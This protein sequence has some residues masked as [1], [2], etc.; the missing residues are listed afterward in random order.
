MELFIELENG[1][2]RG[3]LSF[4]FNKET[5]LQDL[6][7]EIHVK[8]GIQPDDQILFLNGKLLEAV[9][10]SDHLID[11]NFKNKDIIVVRY[12]EYAR[13]EV[14][15]KT[16]NELFH[17]THSDDP[18]VKYDRFQWCSEECRR[19]YG[20]KFDYTF[21]ALLDELYEIK[22]KILCCTD[23]MYPAIK[24]SFI[25]YFRKVFPE[26]DVIVGRKEKGTR[27]GC[28]VR[29]SLNSAVTKFYVK[30]QDNIG[31]MDFLCPKNHPSVDIVELY[32]YKLLE[33]IG[34]C[35]DGHFIHN[36]MESS[37]LI[38]IGT[39][40]IDGFKTLK[41]QPK[42]D[43]D[44]DSKI[45]QGLIKI[46]LLF[47]VLMLADCS[48]G[49][50]GFDAKQDPFIVDF[51]VNDPRIK[52]VQFLDMEIICNCVEAHC[53]R[54]KFAKVSQNEKITIA[55]NF[56]VQSHLINLLEECATSFMVEE[57]PVLE[58]YGML[59]EKTQ[60]LTKYIEKVKENINKVLDMKI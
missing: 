19:L 26:N 8:Y 32:C 22:Q 35:S 57:Q 43:E 41:E 13:F 52:N 10:L 53:Y 1:A 45:C 21:P 36:L 51:F 54:S 15:R 11:H 37:F 6:K 33:K 44:V 60:C 28:V 48:C 24:V 7:T 9:A 23:P 50:V 3:Q 59:E 58:K 17:T 49:N 56:L 39:R 4:V 47:N 55:K 14:L 42:I 20:I 29:V 12:K 2:N 34:L 25:Y 5:T 40:Q 30:T 18:E 27:S 38:Y 31:A 46:L 16:V